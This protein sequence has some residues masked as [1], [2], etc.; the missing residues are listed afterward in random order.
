MQ[1]IEQAKATGVNNNLFD[2]L[3]LGSGGLPHIP[4]REDY[5]DRKVESHLSRSPNCSWTHVLES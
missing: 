2:L 1:K 4:Q 3:F 5:E